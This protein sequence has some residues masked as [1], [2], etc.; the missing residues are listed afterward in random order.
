MDSDITYDSTVYTVKVTTKAVNGQLQAKVE[1][2]KNGIPYANEILFT[3][4]RPMPA[5][6]DSALTVP[7]MLAV[8]G[9]ALVGI[10][11]LLKKRSKSNP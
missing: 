7:L 4:I 5:T 2:E 11:L 6:G 1:L 9:L 10:S 8:A 3:N